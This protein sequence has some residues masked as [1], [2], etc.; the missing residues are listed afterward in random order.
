[1]EGDR[2][3][4]R[5]FGKLRPFSTNKTEEGRSLNRRVELFFKKR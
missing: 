5:A 4:T 2:I 3:R 1:V